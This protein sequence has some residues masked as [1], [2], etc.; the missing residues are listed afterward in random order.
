MNGPVVVIVPV[1]P[2]QPGCRGPWKADQA[3]APIPKQTIIPRP[4]GD[5]V[6]KDSWGTA[7]RLVGRL[8]IWGY[9]PGMGNC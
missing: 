9:L 7:G 1:S 8:N 4:L 5:R 2:D 3:L 6:A